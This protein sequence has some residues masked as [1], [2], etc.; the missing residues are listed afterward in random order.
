MKDFFSGFIRGFR[1]FGENITVIINSALLLFVYI[2][3]VGITSIIA[4]IFGKHFL[5]TKLSRQK[6]SYWCAINSGKKRKEEYYR[7]F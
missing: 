7:Q 1:I 4:K 6:E 3:G 5:E 2:V